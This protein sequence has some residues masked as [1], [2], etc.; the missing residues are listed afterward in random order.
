MTSPITFGLSFVISINHV[1]RDSTASALSTF[2]DSRSLANRGDGYWWTV[3]WTP[4]RT[5]GRALLFSLS[6][7][8][9][10]GD[11]RTTANQNFAILEYF[12][13]W[14]TRN[15]ITRNRGRVVVPSL[16]SQTSKSHRR[17][18]TPTVLFREL[19]SKLT[20][21]N[22]ILWCLWQTYSSLGK[23]FPDNS[24][25]YYLDFPLFPTHFEDR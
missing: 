6:A 4:R 1:S 16:C 17:L 19:Y 3:L 10:L 23:T 22:T 11:F 21:Q 25:V 18:T 20:A 12:E 2:R 13:S 8:L 7:T 5:F 9:N 15:T 14:Q 24:A